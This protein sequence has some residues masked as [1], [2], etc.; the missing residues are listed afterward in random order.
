MNRYFATAARALE[1]IAAREL[2]QL[3]AQ[4]VRPEFAGVHFEGDRALLYRV[5][6]HS[7][8]VFRILAPIAQFKC[9]DADQL[10]RQVRKI[11]WAQY[12][13][14]ENTLAV[15]CTGSN[16]QLNHS[17]FTALQVKNAIV[18]QQRDRFGQRS[19]VDLQ[20]PDLALNAHIQ[21]D[22]C[23]LSLDSTGESLHR[24]GYRPAMGLAPLKETLA[25]A[26][27]EMAQW[28]IQLP[29]F[30]PLCGSGTLPLEAGLKAL[31]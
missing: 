17:H 2:E 24:R 18:D 12:L 19:S 13:Q 30:D 27:L 21:S 31:N 22:R 29:L 14:P 6:L 16:R 25:A 28:D 8:T 4:N 3:G 15:R 23:I 9:R 1:P 26:L 11:D 20:F 10:Y 5:N 7:R